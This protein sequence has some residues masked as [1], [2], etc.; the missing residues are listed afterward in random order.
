MP[1]NITSH[2]QTTFD[3]R[4]LGYNY[5]LLSL[6]RTEKKNKGS[7]FLSSKLAHLLNFNMS[8][9][10]QKQAM[11]WSSDKGEHSIWYIT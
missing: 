5:Q 11:L 1:N 8:S 2:I 3:V 10:I 7:K 4:T 9:T 6:S